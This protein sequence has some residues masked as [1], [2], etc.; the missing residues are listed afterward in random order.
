LSDTD[1]AAAAL[2]AKPKP[3]GTGKKSAKGR[4]PDGAGNTVPPAKNAK[5][6]V[7]M[8][9]SPRR[10]ILMSL[11]RHWLKNKAWRRMKEAIQAQREWCKEHRRSAGKK[12]LPGKESKDKNREGMSPDIV[13][14]YEFI[15]SLCSMNSYLTHTYELV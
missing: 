9:P 6:I 1:D 2:L 12:G 11:L 15:C 8:A 13:I 5:T 14:A 4:A 10:L 3:G 7:A